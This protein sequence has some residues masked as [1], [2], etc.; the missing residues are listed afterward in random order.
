MKIYVEFIPIIIIALVVIFMLKWREDSRKKLLKEYRPEDDK[1]RKG[2]AEI[3]EEQNR[4]REPTIE[5]TT[6]SSIGQGEPERQQLL[7]TTKIDTGSREKSNPK[8]ISNSNK[9]KHRSLKELF[10]RRSSKKTN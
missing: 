10:R 5:S 9:R 2:G 1:S 8:S 7:Q 4:T 6:T 3:F